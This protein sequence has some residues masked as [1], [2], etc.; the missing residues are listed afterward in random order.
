MEKINNIMT[1]GE[2]EDGGHIGH[3]LGFGIGVIEMAL[4][5]GGELGRL[6]V[7]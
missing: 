1:N 7:E 4:K 3:W 5:N 2:I 6:W